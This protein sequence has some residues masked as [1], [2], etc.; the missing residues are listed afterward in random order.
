MPMSTMGIH[1]S[2]K[3][4]TFH[5][6]TIS[7]TNLDMLFFFLNRQNITN[8]QARARRTNKLGW[9]KNT[10]K[11]KSVAIQTCLKLH[12]ILMFKP[13]LFFCIHMLISFIHHMFSLLGQIH[14]VFG[15]Y[16]TSSS[17]FIEL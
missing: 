3:T 4:L 9:K 13:L 8:Q 14:S 2:E 16:G 1:I 15:F 5:R 17:F 11:G 6:Y 7:F 10:N 12:F